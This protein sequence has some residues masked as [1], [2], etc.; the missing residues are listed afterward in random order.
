M[1]EDYDSILTPMEVCEALKI[2]K[3]RLYLL[4]HDQ[5]LPAYREGR[6][7]KISKEGLILYVREQSKLL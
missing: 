6:H 3:S 7:W 4:L 1:F 5:K 2:S